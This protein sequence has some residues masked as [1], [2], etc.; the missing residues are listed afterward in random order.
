MKIHW[1]PFIIYLLLDLIATGAGMGVLIFN[2][3]F[4]FGVGW[5]VLMVVI[6]PFLQILTTVFGGVMALVF[7]QNVPREIPN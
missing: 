2:I 4:G 1:L 5:I 3:L 6:S 7:S